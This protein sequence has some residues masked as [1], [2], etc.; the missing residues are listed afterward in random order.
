MK[1]TR[2]CVLVFV[3]IAL[4]VYARATESG[5]ASPNVILFLVDDMGWM[6]ST[7]YGSQYYDTPNMQRLAKQGM[8]F[9]QAYSQP[10]CSPTRA[11]LLTGQYSAR[12]GITSA[13]GHT[14]PQEARLPPSAPANAPLLMPQSKTFLAL[15]HY[16]LAEALHD[17][18]YRTGHFGKWHLGLTQPHW[19]EQ[20]GF[21][22]AFHCHP[23]PGP[24]NSYFSPY[25]VVPPGTQ[26]QVNEKRILG[27]ITDGPDGEYITDRL[28][29]EALKFI[30]SNKDRPFF[31]NLWHY[32]VHGPWGHK[33]SIT[34]EM[35][36]R[37]DPSGRQKNPV[38]ASML[39]SIDDSLGRILDQLESLGIADD[40]IL[41][42]TSDNGGNTHSLTKEDEAKTKRS[43]DTNPTLASYR[44]WAGFEP[45]TNNA[46]LRDGKGRLYE[47]G[48]RVPLIVRWPGVVAANNTSD[49]IVGCIDVYPTVID[50]LK[51]PANPE[52][53]IDGI[54]YAPILR[55]D[56]TIARDTYFIWFP[57]L[58]AGVSVRQGDWKLI[59]R[60][61][62]RPQ[63]YSGLIELF[64]LKED[65][66]ETTNLAAQHPEKVRELNELI[67]RFVKET[68]AHYPQPNPAYQ[69][70][71]SKKQ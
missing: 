47:G 60:F 22:V 8:R 31:L 30:D 1:N 61:E 46:P 39:K 40:T 5:K 29:E 56:G 7:P 71:N 57:H 44:K 9:T 41:I 17:A 3:L 14:A 20:Q 49:A 68:N 32:G 11:S 70:R 63:D 67:D 10:L 13:V 55:G 36:K 6:D 24:P 69:A 23:D 16:T 25:G 4:P 48:T 53:K 18:G 51:L 2:Y 45:P 38:M 27:T 12:H 34:E 59:R 35:A 42:F 26:R 21:D 52:Q 54:S 43:R 33:E 19:P 64:N 66:G 58:V 50:L 65:L 62:E 37:I 15:E 28:T